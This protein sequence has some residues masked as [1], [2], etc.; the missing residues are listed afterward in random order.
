M[1]TIGSRIDK[2]I[3]EKVNLENTPIRGVF[4]LTKV[5]I[6]DIIQKNGG[7]FMFGFWFWLLISIGVGL[8]LFP[9][10]YF[11]GWWEGKKNGKTEP[12]KQSLLIAIIMGLWPV[13]ACVTTWMGIWLQ[14]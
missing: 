14:L 4:I 3:N 10:T 2:C 7:V 6:V 13:A 8:V 11:Y 9:V 12:K 5:N 1:V